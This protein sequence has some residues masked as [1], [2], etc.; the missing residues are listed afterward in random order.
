MHRTCIGVL[1]SL[2]LLVGAVAS[3]QPPDR[4]VNPVEDQD[5]LR[6]QT[7]YVPYSKLRQ[8]FEQEGRGVF[9]PYDEFQ[10]LWKQ[11]REAMRA[12]PDLRPPVAALITE[13]DSEANVG[14]QVVHVT[15]K[16]Q[17]EVLREG[18]HEIPLRLADASIQSARLDDQPA[19][20]LLNPHAGYTLLVQKQGDQPEQR[21]LTLQYSKAFT[22]AP[23]QNSVSFQ[24]PQAP[25]NQWRVRVGEPGVKVNI[26]PLVAATEPPGASG[27]VPADETILIAFV[28][29]AETL[30]I[31]WTA[32]AEGATGLEALATVEAEQ[33]VSVDE[34]VVK[35]TATLSYQISRAE[36]S[37]LT[38]DAPADHRVLNVFDANVREWTVEPTD[39]LN[40]IRVQLYEP[41][42]QTQRVVIELEQFFSG[43][44]GRQ[45][46]VV[47][48]IQA[49]DVGR[50][51][52]TVLIGVSPALRAEVASRSGLLQLEVS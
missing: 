45:E 24:A 28:G 26:Q 20:L 14:E 43:D 16:L 2:I 46:V 17:L 52:G 19:R 51:Q 4:P 3:A 42:R 21:E 38:I 44:Q 5:F 27:E 15:A 31:D 39:G 1:G 34:G 49:M 13:I 23:G 6:E 35:T 8:V 40:R 36:L 32:K 50:Q 30:R 48:V 22:K 10:K 47:P 18:W 7:I 37:Q 9:L 12:E 11:A 41:A 33:Q 25:V 29:A